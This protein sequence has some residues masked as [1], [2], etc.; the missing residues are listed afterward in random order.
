MPTTLTGQVDAAIGG[1]TGVNTAEGKN[2]AGAFH[3][4]RAVVIDPRLLATLPERERRAGMAEVVKTGLLA[5]QEV[6]T[7][8]ETGDDPRLRRL[9]GRGRALRSVRDRGTPGDG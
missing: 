2:L 5:G 8:A 7:L 1:K 6:W 4:P 3:F 9:Q